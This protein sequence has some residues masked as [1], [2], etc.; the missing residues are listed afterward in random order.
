MDYLV[1]LFKQ[2]GVEDVLRTGL[3]EIVLYRKDPGGE[4]ASGR[5]YA[6]DKRITMHTAPG[7][8]R[9][10]ENWIHEILIHEMGH[11]VHM[12]YLSPEAKKEWDSGWENVEKAKKKLEGKFFVTSQDRHRFFDLIARSGWDPKKAGRKVKGID[13]MKFLAW[14]YKPETNPFI[15]TPNQVRLTPYGRRVFDFFAHPEKARE[16]IAE[17]NPPD[18]VDQILERRRKAFLSNLGLTP[19]Y[20]GKNHPMLSPKMVEKIRSEDHSVDEALNALGIPSDY[21]RTNVRE[22]FAET[23]AAYMTNPSILSPVARYRMER[24]LWLS[25]FH[26]KPVMRLASEEASLLRFAS[27]LPVGDPL[28]RVLLRELRARLLQW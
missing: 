25:G 6:Q 15:S 12:T 27:Y 7:K 14:L 8:G 1:A 2:R 19:Y 9:F 26:G 5:Y 16:E 13:R 4:R 10:I 17:V 11:H 28:R 18:R 21:G 20:E 22:D 3:N 24:A 23:F